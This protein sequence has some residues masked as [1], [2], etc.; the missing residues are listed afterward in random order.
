[1][2]CFSIF[3][4]GLSLL[5]STCLVK[6]FDTGHHWEVTSQVLREMGFSDDARQTAC[7]SNWLLDYYSSSPT[8]SKKVRENLSRLHCD[9]LGDAAAVKRYLDRFLFNSREAVVAEA[10]RTSPSSDRELL[11][12]IGAILHVTQDLYSHSNWPEIYAGKNR[13]SDRTWFKTRGNVPPDLITGAYHPPHYVEDQIPHDHPEHGSYEGGLHKDSHERE[14]WA[15]AYY[16]AYCATHEIMKGIETWIPQERWTRLQKLKLMPMAK[17]EL[18]REIKAAYGISQWIDV[19]GEHGHWKGGQSGDK[20]HF[21]KSAIQF[22]GGV[23][24]NS[25][26]Y[27]MKHGFEPLLPGLYDL[28][29]DQFVE[30]PRGVPLSR[31]TFELEVNRV[32]ALGSR[33]DGGNLYGDP[34]MYLLGAIYYGKVTPLEGSR[35]ER[36]LFGK[37]EPA[38]PVSGDICAL[39]RDRVQQ[40]QSSLIDPWR[41]LIIADSE[42]L[43]RAGGILSLYF[44][45]GEEDPGPDILAD[46]SPLE[47]SRGLLVE[48]HPASGTIVI[49]RMNT[50]FNTKPGT[51]TVKGDDPRAHV[52]M[53]FSIREWKN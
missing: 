10:A 25:R 47:N 49:P 53:T 21:L 41:I 9:N 18:N 37:L 32:E 29:N 16:L 51:V 46:I 19:A 4:L 50:S 34:D 15:Q 14:Y 42:R 28:Q 27:R 12:L 7:V 52:E 35:E 31:K 5:N 1:M 39:F 23:S 40:E 45:I 43:K 13:L 44:N 20:A 26:W 33:L 48:Y 38:P 17:A 3:A 8:G 22:I 2:K 11:L 24:R 36:T 6:A 30:I